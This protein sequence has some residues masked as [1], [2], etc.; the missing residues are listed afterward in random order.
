MDPKS[1]KKRTQINLKIDAAKHACSDAIFYDLAR[2]PTSF[3]KQHLREIDPRAWRSREAKK[4]LQNVGRGSKNQGSSFQIIMKNRFKNASEGDSEKI[5]PKIRQNTIFGALG[6]RFGNRI[7]RILRSFSK[8]VL[9]RHA[10]RLQIGRSQRALE[11]CDCLP[12]L[13]KD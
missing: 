4:T 9:R 5:G 11:V 3:W 8:L 1:L 12:G 6:A 7:R 2:F 13:S 10:T